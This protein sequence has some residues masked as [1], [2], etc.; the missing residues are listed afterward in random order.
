MKVV[1]LAKLDQDF[2][3]AVMETRKKNA[4]AMEDA[5]CSDLGELCEL[6]AVVSKDDSCG[7]SK[8]VG[9]S[10]IAVAM[11]LGLKDIVES[12]QWTDDQLKIFT[13][14][15]YELHV[16]NTSVVEIMVDGIKEKY[17]RKIA[18]TVQ[19]ATGEPVRIKH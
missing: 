4:E 1:D 9:L 8:C 19:I 6:L 10:L 14:V 15:F 12:H 18:S 5:A 3:D 17:M 16:L 13:K 2:L 11:M 7:C